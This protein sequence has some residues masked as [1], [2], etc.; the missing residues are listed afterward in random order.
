[1]ESGF[2]TTSNYPGVNDLQP[3]YDEILN[4]TGCEHVISSLDCLRAL[5]FEKW[6]ASISAYSSNGTWVPV[7]DG[8]IVPM[9]PTDQLAY[10]RFVQVPLLLGGEWMCSRELPTADMVALDPANSD[11]GTA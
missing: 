7:V 1:M 10:Q 4:S 5:P 9:Y 6:N 8:G 2:P 11:E 3:F